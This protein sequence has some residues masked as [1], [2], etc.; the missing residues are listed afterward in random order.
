[1]VSRAEESTGTD[2]VWPALSTVASAVPK[3]IVDTGTLAWLAAAMAWSSDR[4]W[5][6][7]PSDRRTMLA[8]GALAVDEL[9]L[10]VAGRALRA[11]TMA[12]PRAVPGLVARRSR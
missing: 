8:A 6:L 9:A 11:V 4:P 5:V 7:L 2:T 10:A 3:E 12:S 1:M